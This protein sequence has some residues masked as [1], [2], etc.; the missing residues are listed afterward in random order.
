MCWCVV[1]KFAQH[2]PKFVYSGIFVFW[3]FVTWNREV[4]IVGLAKV[5]ETKGEEQAIGCPGLVWKTIE[6]AAGSR[7]SSPG[8]RET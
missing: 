8:S 1:F 5:D 6:V 2:S 3:D 7:P 4:L